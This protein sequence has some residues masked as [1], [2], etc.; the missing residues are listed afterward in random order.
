MTDA[1]KWMTFPQVVAIH[2]DLISEFGGKLGIL[3]EG[4][5][6]STRLRPQQ[7]IYYQPS[8]SIYDLAAVYGYGLAKNH[9]FLDGNKRTAFAVMATF[10][11]KNGYELIAT[12]VEAVDVMLEIVL[13]NVSQTELSEW[14]SQNSQ[15][16]A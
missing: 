2:N 4:A 1:Y 12:E 8:S 15:K 6:E 13:G 7:T 3:N 11:L 5:L 16:I 10:L 9:C 14:L